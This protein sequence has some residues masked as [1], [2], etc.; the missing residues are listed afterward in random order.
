M[1]RLPSK[2]V[3]PQPHPAQ[4]PAARTQHPGGATTPAPATLQHSHGKQQGVSARPGASLGKPPLPFLTDKL[5]RKMCP[6]HNL[7]DAANTAPHMP[8][9]LS[10]RAHSLEGPRE[11]STDSWREVLFKQNHQKA[12]RHIFPPGRLF[13]RGGEGSP[14]RRRPARRLDT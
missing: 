9:P 3:R 2:V 8:P 7:R 12:C 1:G 14:W 4:A 6:T 10:P 5:T 11:L 13:D